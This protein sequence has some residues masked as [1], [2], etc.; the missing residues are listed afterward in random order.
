[1]K[2]NYSLGKESCRGNAVG[3]NQNSKR[4]FKFIKLQEIPMSIEDQIHESIKILQS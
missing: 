4:Y 2:V 3:A 1:M